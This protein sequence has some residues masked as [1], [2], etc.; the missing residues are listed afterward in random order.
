MQESR[1]VLITG[2]SGGIGQS[3]AEAVAKAGYTVVANYNRNKARAEALEA[4]IKEAGGQV[5][6]LQFDISNRTQCKDV[7][8][9]DIAENGIYYGII[10]NAGVCD[11]MTFAAMGPDSWD[12]VIG[13]N[14]GGFYNVISR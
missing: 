1:Q 3:I 8:E 11:D 7:L 13:T 6:L 2:A 14:L 9:K 4:Q 10:L 5:R 12:K